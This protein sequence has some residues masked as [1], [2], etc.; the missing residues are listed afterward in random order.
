MRRAGRRAALAG[1][2]AL[3]V[4]APESTAFAQTVQ[5]GVPD[6]R[7]ETEQPSRWYGW[8]TL[9]SD[10]ASIGVALLGAHAEQDTI[11]VAGFTGLLVGPPMIHWGHGQVGEGF[12]SLA[13]RAPYVGFALAAGYGGC[14]AGAPEDPDPPECGYLRLGFFLGALAMPVAII[15]DAAVLAYDDP[16]PDARASYRVA[17]WLDAERSAGGASLVG[18]F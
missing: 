5:D 9:L 4:W 16:E 2:L 12:G 1:A 17:P 11:L 7:A 10:A 8:Q 13:L 18:R 14:L 3:A 6:E 15:V